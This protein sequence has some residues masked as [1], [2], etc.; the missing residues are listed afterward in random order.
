[1]TSGEIKNDLDEMMT[2]GEIQN[3]LDKFLPEA[4]TTTVQLPSEPPS[5][6]VS[7]EKATS[8]PAASVNSKPVATAGLTDQPEEA[9][10]VTSSPAVSSVPAHA[11]VAITP[12]V[13]PQPVPTRTFAK[14]ISALQTQLLTRPSTGDSK[15]NSDQKYTKKQSQASK[16]AKEDASLPGYSPACQWT[17][18]DLVVAKWPDGVWR[19]A[20]IVEMDTSAGHAMV[21]G[22]G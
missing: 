22:E 20:T 11:T 15:D 7:K 6:V 17:A 16:V 8:P 4:K 2:S 9:A 5:Q 1:M 10:V 19:H 14:A 3:D 13:V 21:V 12:A 18:G